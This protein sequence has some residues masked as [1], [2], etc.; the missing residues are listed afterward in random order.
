MSDKITSL[1][2]IKQLPIIE[3]RLK[4]ISAEIDEKIAFAD[5]LACTEATVKEVKAIRSELNSE[6]AALEDQRKK[7]KTAV[8]EPYLQFEGIYKEYVIDKYKA[9]DSRLKSRID[10]VEDE[11]K[12]RKRD[13]LEAYF[14]EYRDSLGID[15]VSMDAWD[16]NITLSASLASLKKLAKTYLDSVADALALIDTHEYREEVLVEYKKSLNAPQAITTVVAR[17]KDIEEQKA[18]AAEAE[19]RAAAEREAVARVEQHAAQTP[20]LEP[21]KPIRAVTDE[22]EEED[23]VRTLQF[24]VTGP[25]SKLRQLKQFLIEGGYDFE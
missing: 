24:K 5:S 1:I 9:A 15:I 19:A 8:M 2:T 11:L 14:N 4:S 22:E 17:H 12:Q 25:V 21:G 10:A 3:E 23:P 18:K 6:S 13:S 7:I 20:P 16:P